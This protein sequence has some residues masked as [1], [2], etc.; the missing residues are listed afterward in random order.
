MGIGAIFSLVIGIVF[1]IYGIL[2]VNHYIR[3]PEEERALIITSF[4][5]ILGITGIIGAVTGYDGLVGLILLII[6]VI[7]SIY[8]KK[9]HPEIEKH[10]EMYHEI[11]GKDLFS[12]IS[13]ILVKIAVFCS[14]LL[15]LVILVIVFVH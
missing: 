14:V 13:K 9:K 6:C 2:L 15:F 10:R 4:S 8:L 12:T 1:I 7:G 3:K 5:F 11:Y